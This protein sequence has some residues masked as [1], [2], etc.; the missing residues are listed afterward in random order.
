MQCTT[1]LIHYM[2]ITIAHLT[3]GYSKRQ[4]PIIDDLELE[5]EP[6]RVYGL[7]GPNGAG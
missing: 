7:L 1:T 3:F 2:M 6:G 4:K 5:L